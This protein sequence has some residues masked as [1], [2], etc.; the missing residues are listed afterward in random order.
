[1]CCSTSRP[2]VSYSF[3]LSS[4]FPQSLSLLP[5]IPTPNLPLRRRHG[6]ADRLAHHLP[7]SK[8]SAEDV[9]ALPHRRRHGSGRRGRPG[10]VGVA[11]GNGL[12]DLGGRK[13]EMVSGTSL[14]FFLPSEGKEIS[15]KI[16]R[17]AKHR[18]CWIRFLVRFLF[19][20]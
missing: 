6:Q 18:I 12:R 13:R 17:R 5:S 9:V 4:S 8:R 16:A 10:M 15:S 1:M 19:F 14:F 3:F 11:R 20:N 7:G 2:H